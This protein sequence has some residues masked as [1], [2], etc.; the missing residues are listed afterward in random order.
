MVSENAEKRCWWCG[1][2]ALY[3][4]YHDE[5]WGVP[6]HDDR[7][8]F[9]MLTLEFF[10]AG[11]SWIT[12][13]KKRENFRRAF[14][15]F[16]VQKVAKY[17]QKKEEKLVLD[18]GIIRHRGKIQSAI[19]NAQCF[20]ALAEEFGSF[21]KYVWRFTDGIALRSPTDLTREEIPTTSPE[22]QALSKDLKKRGFRFMGPTICYA[23][24]QSCGMVDDHTL[25]CFKY[26]ER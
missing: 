24:M 23:L 15:S 8:W 14:D 1:D 5:E 3:V 18:A 11:L 7:V 26:V 4:A 10:Q 17:T 2:D 22:S 25:G 6:V 9:E 21:D 19:S 12:I 13:L 16:D 20:I